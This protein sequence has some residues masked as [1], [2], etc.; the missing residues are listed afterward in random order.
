M[1]IYPHLEHWLGNVYVLP[2]YRNQGVG[3]QITETAVETAKLL[4]V[5]NL[6]LYTRDREHFYRRLGW[7]LLEQA[8]YRGREAIVMSRTIE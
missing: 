5:K 6:Y 4:G 1:E 8:E 3:S 7:K 2:E